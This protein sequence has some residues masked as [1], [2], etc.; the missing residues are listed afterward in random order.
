MGMVRETAID[1]R[2]ASCTANSR[3]CKA[4]QDYSVKIKRK[5]PTKPSFSETYNNSHD[6]PPLNAPNREP[7][8][9]ERSRAPPID[10]PPPAPDSE[11]TNLKDA[12]E[13]LQK[14]PFLSNLIREVKELARIANI[15]DSA[16]RI[17]AIMDLMNKP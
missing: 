13:D 9:Y 4:Y 16:A 14:A 12:I 2:V 3:D 10:R 11:Y 6:F 5:T 8:I 7:L 15:S 1:V 17:A